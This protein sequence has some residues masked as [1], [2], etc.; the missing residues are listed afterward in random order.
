MSW[1][2]LRLFCCCSDLFFPLL[3]DI[4]GNFRGM[5]HFIYLYIPR[6]VL[7]QVSPGNHS[8]S[9]LLVSIPSCH[10]R[11]CCRY[12]WSSLGAVCW[13]LL[14]HFNFLQLGELHRSIEPVS[15]SFNGELAIALFPESLAYEDRTVSCIFNCFT[16]TPSFCVSISS[17][18]LDAL[19]YLSQNV[20]SP[21][22]VSSSANCQ[23][24]HEPL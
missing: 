24:P 1:F 9:V 12:S 15:Y 7:V 8:H 3:L 23:L 21:L 17:G 22:Q 2:S 14:F 18:A 10:R 4:H 16:S 5:H 19:W 6:A 11:S 13:I 20:T